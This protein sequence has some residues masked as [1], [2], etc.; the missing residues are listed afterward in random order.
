[1]QISPYGPKYSSLAK[2]INPSYFHYHMASF[3]H[4]MAQTYNK[5]TEFKQTFPLTSIK[6]RLSYPLHL[7]SGK[8]LPPQRLTLICYCRK[9]LFFLEN[10]SIQSL[11]L[12]YFFLK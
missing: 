5:M 9:C 2:Q 4:M 8:E 12:I 3:C 1:M 6:S 11:L 10:H 7:T